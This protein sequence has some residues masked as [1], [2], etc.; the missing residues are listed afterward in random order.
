MAS[1]KL[2][3]KSQYLARIEELPPE[4]L[5]VYN[6]GIYNDNI[7]NFPANLNIG[8]TWTM[9]FWAKPTS[10]K[11]HATFFAVGN[12]DGRNEIQA[13]TTAIPAETQI[14]GKRTSE[15]RV[16][17]KDTQGATIK[18]YGWP[19]WFQ[20]EVWTHTFL[21][22]DGVDLE[23]FHNALTTTT[24]VVLVDASGNMGDV[25]VRR[26]YYGSAIVGR[27]ATF[28]GI[29]GHFGVW[30]SLLAPEELGTVVSGGFA[31]DLTVSSGSYTSQDN[32]QHYWKPGDD[33]TN[34]GR[35][36]T[37]SGTPLDL[38]KQRNLTIDDITLDSP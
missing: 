8:N 6:T 7:Y 20:T 16:I 4:T 31:A 34:L 33:P 5:G 32:L 24:G 3:G 35:D 9:G 22:W 12:Q 10:N 13:F 18:H 23:A 37:T 11:E 2:D 21:E 27:F 14:H 30:D 15:L 17:I 25:P 28:S 36:F 1:L 19:N 26:V 29:L 38:T